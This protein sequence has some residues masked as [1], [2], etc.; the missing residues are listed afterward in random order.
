MLRRIPARAS[1]DRQTN[2]LEEAAGDASSGSEGPKVPLFQRK[3]ART[4][5]PRT[6]GRGTR[7]QDRQARCKG[8]APA[9]KDV[10]GNATQPNNRRRTAKQ[11]E[12]RAARAAQQAVKVGGQGNSQYRKNLYRGSQEPCGC[13]GRGRRACTVYCSAHLLGALVAGSAFGIF[14]SSGRPG[15]GMTLKQAVQ[16][17]NEEYSPEAQRD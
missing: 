2:R 11:A 6:A 15:K 4:Q 8:A 13:V 7:P 10:A 16:T 14:F 1:T 3:K 5:V 9:G 17:L 12:K